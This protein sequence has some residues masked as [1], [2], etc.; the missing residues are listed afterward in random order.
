MP[1]K[2]KLVKLDPRQDLASAGC[3]LGTCADP[4]TYENWKAAVYIWARWEGRVTDIDNGFWQ[5]EHQGPGPYPNRKGG[6]DAV[7][8]ILVGRPCGKKHK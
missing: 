2:K 6:R 8:F 1:P 7:V 4:V 5:G 3:R